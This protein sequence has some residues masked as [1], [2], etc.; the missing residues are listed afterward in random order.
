[1]YGFRDKMDAI[2]DNIADYFPVYLGVLF[3]LILGGIVTAVIV[4]HENGIHAGTVTSKDDHPAYTS[5]LCTGKPMV[6]YPQYHPETWSVTIAAGK[7]TN[8]FDLPQSQ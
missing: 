6:C 8:D 2:R 5:M 1:M 3:I 4:N 7:Q